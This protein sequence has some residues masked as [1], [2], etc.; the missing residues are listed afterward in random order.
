MC[1]AGLLL[2]SCYICLNVPFL[3]RVSKYLHSSHLETFL[4]SRSV[5]VVD[6]EESVT[7]TS[8]LSNS[9]GMSSKPAVLFFSLQGWPA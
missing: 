2:S 3:A 1:R 7:S 4:C 8:V 9:E 6:E 5:A